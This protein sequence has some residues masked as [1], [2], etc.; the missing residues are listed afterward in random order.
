MDVNWDTPAA[1]SAPPGPAP[2]MPPAPL[3]GKAPVPE[4]MPPAPVADDGLAWD[5]DTQ[6]TYSWVSTFACRIDTTHSRALVRV[7]VRVCVRARAPL[8]TRECL[9]M[10]L[11]FFLSASVS[12][13]TLCT[14]TLTLDAY[15]KFP[16]LLGS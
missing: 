4:S 5:E 16:T 11:V 15:R 12:Q 6:K 7:R 3:P 14:H 13:V 8:C 9:D 1:A 2:S 10:F